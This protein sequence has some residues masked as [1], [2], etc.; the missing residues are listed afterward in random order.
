MR[1]QDKADTVVGYW[2]CLFLKSGG[3][4]FVGDLL[5]DIIKC[6]CGWGAWSQILLL[7]AGFTSSLEF[8]GPM[9]IYLSLVKKDA[10]FWSDRGDICVRFPT[11]LLPLCLPPSLFPCDLELDVY[12]AKAGPLSQDPPP[13]PPEC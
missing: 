9:K 2:K 8:C 7:A 13:L 6:L 1:L 3:Y 10:L 11:S 4:I 12:V 5:H